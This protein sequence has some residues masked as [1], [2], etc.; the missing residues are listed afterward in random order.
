ME[1]FLYVRQGVWNTGEKLVCSDGISR[2]QG[3]EDRPKIKEG[4]T[5]HK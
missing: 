5:Q 3:G 2:Q 1:Y 4:M